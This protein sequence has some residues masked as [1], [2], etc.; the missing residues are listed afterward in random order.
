M[1]IDGS[2]SVELSAAVQDYAKAIYE[3][4]S[5]GGVAST[6]ALADRL[7]VRPASVSGMLRKLD[8]LGLVVHERY[9]G[10][11]LTDSGRKVALEVLR[12]HRLLELYLAENLGLG[13]DE[14]HAEAE[15]LEHVLSEELEEAIATKLGNPTIDPHGDPIPTRELAV[16]EVESRSLYALEPGERGIFI[17][18]SDS[19]SEML[20]FLEARAIAP[21]ASLE[22][23]DKQP[24]DGPLFVRVGDEV[25]VLGAVLARAMRVT[26]E[27]QR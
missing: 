18:V 24:F 1:T 16:V 27:E 6:N 5:R 23:I 21:G 3:L 26:I 11:R 19:D 4:E 15:R 17:R 13:W 9:R 7:G 22:L 20:R 8:T 14:V 2:G 12:H 10:V 25:H